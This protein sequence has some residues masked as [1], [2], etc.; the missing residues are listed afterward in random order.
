MTE[1]P[2]PATRRR[3]LLQTGGGFAGALALGRAPAFAQTAPK[4]L[5][6]A[7]IV[8]PP[9]SSAVAFVEMADAINKRAE[10]GLEIEFHAGTLLT[11]ELEVINA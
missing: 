7:H 4:K 3:F 10:G 9:E 8:A 11:K 5:V 1:S 6:M 2:P